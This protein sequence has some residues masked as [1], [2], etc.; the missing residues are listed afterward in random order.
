MKRFLLLSFTFT[1][2]CAT[3]M[4]GTDES[5]AISSNPSNAQVFVDNNYIGSTPTVVK[6]SRKDKHAV[7][8]RI[9]RV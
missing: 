2:S 4:H 1:H 7:K 6:M 5:V 3:I 8:D 9:K